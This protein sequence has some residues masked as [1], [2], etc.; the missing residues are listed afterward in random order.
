MIDRLFNSG[1]D[2]RL[3]KEFEPD[4]YRQRHPDL[5]EFS[6][7]D[8]RLHYEL[9]GRA[10]GRVASPCALREEFLKHVKVASSV[11]E[12]GPFCNPCL[13]GGNVSYFDVLDQE[14]LLNRAADVGYPIVHAPKIDFV[15]PTGDMIVVDRVFASVL[16]SHCI[17][18]QP[19]LVRHLQDVERV[20]L[21]GGCYFIIVPDKRYCFDHFIDPSSVSD[22]VEA[23]FEKHRVHRISSV[24]EH[25]A[26]T[27]HNDS[28]RHWIGDNGGFGE[29]HAFAQRIRSAITEFERAEGAYIDVHAWQFTPKSIRLIFESLQELELIKLECHRVYDTPFGRNEFTAVLKKPA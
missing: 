17:E 24:I 16:S 29:V 13:V 25:R 12:I 20:L 27:T 11:L 1:R 5:K 10:E 23:F 7:D 2:A 3:P 15:S 26:M 4:F 8:L 21:P 6:D 22:V 18:H 28:S 9:H 19:D 14:G